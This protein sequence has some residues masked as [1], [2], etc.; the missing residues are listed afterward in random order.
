MREDYFLA[1]ES[2]TA[3]AEST[4]AAAESTTE[5]AEST[6]AA[7]ESVVVS[8]AF[9][10][11]QAANV[12]IPATNAKANNFFISLCDVLDRKSVV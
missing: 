3:A 9:F 7:T 10:S 5:A 2:T 6:V 11:P 4:V 12:T 1:A 8:A